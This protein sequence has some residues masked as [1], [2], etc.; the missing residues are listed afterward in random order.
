MGGRLLFLAAIAA[1]QLARRQGK[2]AASQKGQNVEVFLKSEHFKFLPLEFAA[3]ELAALEF[4]A[5][6]TT[7]IW[8]Y[9]PSNE[10]KLGG[11]KAAL[12]PGA[13]SSLWRNTLSQ[14]PSV[15]GKLVYL[16]A[17]RN[18]N[19]GRYEHHGLTLLFGEDEAN[20]ALRKSHSEAFA[21]WLTFNLQQQ[22]ADLE[23]YISEVNEEPKTVLATWAHLAPYR[24][25]IP[26]A[27]RGV[28]RRLFVGD[29]T[30]LLR[31][32]RSAYGVAEPDP[33]A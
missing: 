17:L 23:L 1:S 15:F 16:S 4:A 19:N 6:P 25:L 12:T 3:L 27:V 32:L 33:D 11:D 31:S 26:S 28:E 2:A 20:K 14:I 5:V 21:Q 22:K 18:P 30:V 7:P 10:M 29:L 13:L 9:D 8:V 24:N